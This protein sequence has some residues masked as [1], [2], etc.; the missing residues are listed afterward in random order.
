MKR[1]ELPGGVARAKAVL[2]Q[3]QSK[4][5]VTVFGLSQSADFENT[6]RRKNAAQKT[7]CLIQPAKHF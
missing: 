6:P 7:D 4:R 1:Y 2:K 5:F 3:P